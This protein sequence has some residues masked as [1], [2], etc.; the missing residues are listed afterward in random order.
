MKSKNDQ[1]I[2]PLKLAM[3]IPHNASVR[4]LSPLIDEAQL[5]E[6]AK[7][8]RWDARARF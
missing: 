7:E 5:T 6:S 2:L 4:V 1:V 8:A 3:N